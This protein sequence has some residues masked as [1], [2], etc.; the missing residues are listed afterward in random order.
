MWQ[1]HRALCLSIFC[2]LGAPSS[3]TIPAMSRYAPM[4]IAKRSGKRSMSSPASMLNIG[5]STYVVF[6][7]FSPPFVVAIRFLSL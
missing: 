7:V 2:N 5:V 1:G 6:I 4:S 3:P